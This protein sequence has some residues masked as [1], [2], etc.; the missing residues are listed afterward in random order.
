LTHVL[1]Q[2]LPQ[3]T[4]PPTAAM[5]VT[6]AFAVAVLL[7]SCH[8]VAAKREPSSSPAGLISVGTDLNELVDQK[9]PRW[10]GRRSKSD[11]PGPSCEHEEAQKN[12][13]ME[14]LRTQMEVE[15]EALRKQKEDEMQALRK[16]KEGEVEALRA[17]VD[18]LGSRLSARESE[19]AELKSERLAV[20]AKVKELEALPKQKEEEVAALRVH[21]DDL[22]SRLSARE[23]EVAELKS[24]RLAVDAKVKVL[25][26]EQERNQNALA[27][28]DQAREEVSRMQ[29]QVARYADDIMKLSDRNAQ[30]NSKLQRAEEKLHDLHGEAPPAQSEAAETKPGNWLQRLQKW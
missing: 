11:E 20:D 16:Q 2:V 19:V 30:L 1:T 8:G 3:S 4:Q 10:F 13:E 27:E 21:V 28:R 23:S 5:G 7:A 14:A 15:L 24:E 17:H 29:A 25:E 26:T 9:R 22:G 12:D 6:T 18:D